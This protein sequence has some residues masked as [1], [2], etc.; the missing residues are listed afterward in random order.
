ML[1]S[2]GRPPNTLRQKLMAAEK[3]AVRDGL[4][5]YM[6]LGIVGET[7]DN[8]L[9]RLLALREPAQRKPVGPAPNCP[10]CQEKLAW[11]DAFSRVGTKYSTAALCEGAVVAGHL[12]YCAACEDFFHT[13][14]SPMVYY[15]WPGD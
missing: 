13:L 10:L 12:W 8:R 5:A 14:A 6:A 3:Q 9:A 2:I 15:G 1:T 4:A 7:V 11:D